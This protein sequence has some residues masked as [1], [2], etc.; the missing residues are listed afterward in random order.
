[1]ARLEI[2]GLKEPRS[3]GRWRLPLVIVAAVGAAIGFVICG[4]AMRDDGSGKQSKDRGVAD[5]GKTATRSLPAWKAERTKARSRTKEIKIRPSPYSAGIWKRVEKMQPELIKLRRRLHQKPELAN[6]ER[7]TA[8]RVAKALQGLGLEVVRNVASTGVTALLKGKKPGPTIALVAALDGMA[9]KE[10]NPVDYASTQQS[11]VGAGEKKVWVSHAMGHDVEISVLIGVARVLSELT[12]VM[13]GA[14]KL[15]FT[16]ATDG[17]SAGERNG[18]AAMVAQGVLRSPAVEALFALTLDPTVRVGRVGMEA[19]HAWR[20]MTHFEV[21]VRGS[22][23]GACLQLDPAGC[24]DA[25]L[26]A[27]QLVVTLQSQVGRQA[28]G[29]DAVRLTVGKLDGAAQRGRLPEV[30]TLHG[31]LRWQRRGA[32]RKAMTFIQRTARGLALS[33]RARIQVTFDEGARMVS[34]DPRLVRWIR[35]TAR[36]TLGPR[37]VVTGPPTRLAAKSFAVFRRRVPA[38]L[39]RLGTHSAKLGT[40][41][42]LRTGRFNVDEECLSVGVH[43]LSN[44]VLD[45]LLEAAREKTVNGGA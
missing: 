27:A 21:R 7:E 16:P 8:A 40:E 14:V 2:K 45:Y 34:S 25:V 17:V 43:F 11:V 10:T 9:V 39:I 31:T 33:S 30:V 13:P 5:D 41:R 23:S 28:G 1:M 35:P 44:V 42:K 4:R 20:G 29:G 32:A 22:G 24:V 3:R 18:P 19:A 15:I 36:R 12:G 26:T 37:G 38:V 6:R